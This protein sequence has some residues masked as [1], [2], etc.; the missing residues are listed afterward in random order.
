MCVAIRDVSDRKRA[1]RALQE[2]YQRLAAS[3]GELERHDSDM[4][5][6]NEMG[7]GGCPRMTPCLPRWATGPP[8]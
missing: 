6:V 3:V 5:L 2:A 8:P 4:T 7:I 1:E